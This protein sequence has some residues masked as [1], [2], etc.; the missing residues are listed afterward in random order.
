MRRAA[1]GGGRAARRRP[2][3]GQHFLADERILRRIVDA[4]DPD[5]ADVV[6]EIGAGTGTLTRQLARRVGRVVAIEKDRRR[7]AECGVRNAEGGVA[8]VE[9]IE[10][11]ALH[12]DWHSLVPRSALR[13]PHFKI[14]GNIPYYITAPLIERALTPPA[15]ERVVFLVQAEVAE[16]IVAPPGSRTYG[17]LSVGVQVTSRAERLF[18]VKAGAFR[19]PPAVDSA[20]IRLRPRPEVAWEPSELG[21]LR[22]F[23]T[24]CFSR[25]RKQL[26]NVLQGAT[27][28]PA[29]RVSGLLE[30]LGIDRAARPET[31]SPETF[32]R[33]WRE[34]LRGRGP[35]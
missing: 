28:W 23:V 26:R 35:L 22:R 14:V 18:G 2:A 7:A 4:L 3:L 10:G 34:T 5:R 33:V 21:H 13:T 24:A 19:P 20:V 27:G 6:L 29:Q 16:R 12:L 32:V 17:A 11:D 25:R 8:N 31:L 1:K 30:R 15:P 9:I